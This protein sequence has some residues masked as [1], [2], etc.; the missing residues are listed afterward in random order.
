ME[1]QERVRHSPFKKWLALRLDRAWEWVWTHKLRFWGL[2]VALATVIIPIVYFSFQM[3]DR[4]KEQ[5]T[6]NLSGSWVLIMKVNSAKRGDFIGMVKR[7][8]MNIRHDKAGL[9]GQGEE[10][11]VDGKPIEFKNRRPISIDGA[12]CGDK[13]ILTFHFEGQLRPTNGNIELRMP[14]AAKMYHG[15]FKWDMSDSAGEVTLLKSPP[16]TQ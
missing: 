10:L 11:S 14:H 3:T 15:I 8:S 1:K 2:L 12:I 7:F 13:A 16:P 6:P 5:T 4:V 9:K